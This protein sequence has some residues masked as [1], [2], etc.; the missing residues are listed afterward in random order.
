MR[1]DGVDLG[2]DPDGR[3]GLGSRER[4]ALAGQAAADYEYVV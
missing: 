2:H 3:A 4:R 1:A